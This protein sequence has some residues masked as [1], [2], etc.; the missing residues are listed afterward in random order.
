[1]V[2]LIFIVVGLMIPQLIFNIVF[3]LI[4]GLVFIGGADAFFSALDVQIGAHGITSQKSLFG[5]KL[6]EKFIPSYGL[7]GF[8]ASESYSSSSGNKT[9]RYFNLEAH[10]NGGEKIVV[11]KKLKG[12][13]EVDAAIKKF[14]AL[15]QGYQ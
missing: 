1:M 6:K 14:E 12:Q 13:E 10:G 11:A 7:K 8:V 3:P 2:G 9:T 5:F 4:G 15:T